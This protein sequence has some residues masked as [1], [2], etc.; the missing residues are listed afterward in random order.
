MQN[1]LLNFEW[2]IVIVQFIAAIVL[3]LIVNWFGK[4]AIVSYDYTSITIFTEEESA[5]AF[6]IIYRVVAPIIFFILYMALVQSLNFH[7]LSQNSNMIVVYYW[8]IR[9]IFRIC[10]GRIKLTNLYAYFTCAIISVGLTYWIYSVTSEVKS[11]LPFPHT[12]IDE[13]WILIILFIYN[14]F[15][16]FIVI[17]CLIKRKLSINCFDILRK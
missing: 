16:K 17:M 9:T 10:T 6:N 5:P 11:I 14:V 2:G 7:R 8:V 13:I 12:L 3:F 15:N 4:H 1:C